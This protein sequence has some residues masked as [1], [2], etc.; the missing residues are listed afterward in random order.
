MLAAAATGYALAGSDG[1]PTVNREALAESTNP[2]GAPGRT[3]G[4]SRVTVQPGA[5]LALHRHQGTQIARV[6]R[7]VLTYAV[8]GGGVKVRRGTPGEGARVVR[9]IGPG[10]HGK[11]RAGEWIVEQP[12]TIHRAAN[13]G[14]E[15]VVIY[16][17]TLL[18]DGAAPSIP[19]D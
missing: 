15:R 1:E 6:H 16:L 19:V 3:L 13:R 5:K 12:T 7:G 17:A 4:L 10:D 2:R 9:R 18:R 11:L 8:R 14:Q